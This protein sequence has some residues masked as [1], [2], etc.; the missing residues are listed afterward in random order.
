MSRRPTPRPAGYHWHQADPVVRADGAVPCR[1]C[2][3]PVLPP[4][5]TFCGDA[6]GHR[7]ALR[8][9]GKLCRVVCRD[10]DRGVCALCGLDCDALRREVR[11]LCKDGRP[12]HAMALCAAAGVGWRKARSGDSLWVADHIVPVAEGGDWFDP[13][14]LQT[15]CIPCDRVKT[16]EDNRRMAAARRIARASGFGGGRLPGEV[17]RFRTSGGTCNS[18]GTS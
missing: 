7:W 3:G 15:L 14:N 16:A 10:R 18:S 5:R 9:S 6:C 12:S 11:D 13:D 1:E 17:S 2:Q 8:R 4:R